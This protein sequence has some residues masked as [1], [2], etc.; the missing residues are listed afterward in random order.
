M[1]FAVFLIACFIVIVCVN[2]KPQKCGKNQYYS[3]CGTTCPRTC[4]HVRRGLTDRDI[5]CTL[6][7]MP[8]CF[9]NSGYVRNGKQCVLESQCK[10]K[11]F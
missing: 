11:T 9:C 7:C 1:K 4:E 5:I 2:A 10:R 3:F 6:D 8:G